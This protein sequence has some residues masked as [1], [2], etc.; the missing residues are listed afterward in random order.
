MKKAE[1]D[2]EVTKE[3]MVDYS[4]NIKDQY[5]PEIR[6]AK[7][8]PCE[9][10]ATL[11]LYMFEDYGKQDLTVLGWA[12]FDGD[13]INII[14]CYANSQKPLLWYVPFQNPERPIEHPDW[15]NPMQVEFLSRV[16][17]WH[18]PKGYFGEQAHFVKV[19]PLNVS[20]AQ[21]LF[22]CG[23]RL[24]CNTK[25]VG[26]ETRRHATALL[27]PKMRFNENSDG[28]MELYDAIQQSRYVGTNAPVSRETSMKPRHD[29]EI[30]DYRSALENLSVNVPRII[31]VQRDG[32]GEN[33]R[34]DDFASAIMKYLR[35]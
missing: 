8:E 30:G 27:L 17:K 35:V 29:D 13:W 12:Q 28:V 16:R 14:D 25:A 6:Q 24:M 31:R 9:Y 19:M 3:I 34:K 33:F 10:N 15:Y 2:P 32:V 11:P 21:E 5:Y 23:I 4:V 18:K 1:F 26:Y 7:L 20:I 22:R